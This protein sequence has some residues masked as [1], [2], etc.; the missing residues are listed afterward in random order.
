MRTQTNE[1][2][3]RLLESAKNSQFEFEN[4]IKQYLA[5]IKNKTV[6]LSNIKLLQKGNRLEKKCMYKL[7]CML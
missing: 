6:F 5:S 2:T 1:Q 4:R 3:N 7:I